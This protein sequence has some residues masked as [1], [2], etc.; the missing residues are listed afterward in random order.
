MKT[1][2]KSIVRWFI[3]VLVVIIAIF[4]MLQ[5]F[6]PIYYTDYTFSIKEIGDNTIVGEKP[7]VMYINYNKNED[8]ERADGNYVKGSELKA[9]DEI[10][11]FSYN[12]LIFT[13]AKIEESKIIVVYKNYYS[14]HINDA[15]IEN[16]RGE[17][18]TASDL[19]VG[20]YI[21]VRTKVDYSIK[22][23]I[24]IGYGNPYDDG[25]YEILNNVKY[26]KVYWY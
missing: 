21:L 11:I 6:F 18:I 17:R 9:G 3:I 5:I 8:Y 23:N 12:D 19:K 16:E 4:I 1:K 15:I 26:I 22:N 2:T 20:D 10:H 24:D 14:L 13:V 7:L 25:Y